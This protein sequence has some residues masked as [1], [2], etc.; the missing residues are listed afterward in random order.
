MNKYRSEAVACQRVLHLG[1]LTAKR[2]ASICFT[3]VFPKQFNYCCLGIFST[4]TVGDDN[5]L[6]IH[7]ANKK[8]KMLVMICL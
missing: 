5:A 7:A 6:F 1:Y 8:Y 3:L 2:F 4:E